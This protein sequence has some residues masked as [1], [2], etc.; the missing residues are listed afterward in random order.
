M[1]H[2]RRGVF[3]IKGIYFLYSIIFYGK[4]ASVS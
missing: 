4:G 3:V 1:S 2:V